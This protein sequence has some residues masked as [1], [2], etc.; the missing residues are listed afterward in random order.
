[1][2]IP[3]FCNC[4]WRTHTKNGS[5]H[6]DNCTSSAARSRRQSRTSSGGRRAV[7]SPA[8]RA[9]TK[10]TGACRHRS[11]CCQHMRARRARRAHIFRAGGAWRARVRYFSPLRPTK[12]SMCPC[13]SVSL[14]PADMQ[15]APLTCLWNLNFPRHAWQGHHVWG[16]Q[17]RTRTPKLPLRGCPL[18]L[19]IKR[20]RRQHHTRAWRPRR[21]R[22]GSVSAWWCHASGHH[23]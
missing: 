19:C 15:A 8:P 9:T 17:H 1:M 12:V 13:Q 3:S 11:D 10:S 22:R 14:E 20:A 6:A 18:F 23:R 2:R 16:V 21:R 4:R 7:R 5:A